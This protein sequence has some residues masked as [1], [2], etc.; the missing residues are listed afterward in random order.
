MGAIARSLV[1]LLVVAGL[2]SA[3]TSDVL[4]LVRH[5]AE[6]L[7][8][9]EPN[10][11]LDLFDRKSPQFPALHTKVE[12][13]LAAPVASTIDVVSDEGSSTKRELKL[14]WVI[15]VG[16]GISAKAAG[17]IDMVSVAD[18]ALVLARAIAWRGETLPPRTMHL[19]QRLRER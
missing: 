5:A 7:A 10:T 8:D 12:A 3:Q 11:F 16:P 1:G 15:R 19:M 9:N 2:A 6:A 18:K 4:D 14:D 17:G 13:L